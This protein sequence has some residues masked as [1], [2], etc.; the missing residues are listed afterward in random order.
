MPTLPCARASWTS[1][2]NAV[3]V[4]GAAELRQAFAA[5]PKPRFDSLYEGGG[6]GRDLQEAP[7]DARR[8]EYHPRIGERYEC[9]VGSRRE[10]NG[11]RPCH[12]DD[13]PTRRALTC[14]G[15]END[16]ILD[17]E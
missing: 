15:Q 1:F 8:D 4:A 11:A 14:G 12:G 13:D 10:Q 7:L 9:L 3:R 17:R 5:V 6:R 16:S 2:S